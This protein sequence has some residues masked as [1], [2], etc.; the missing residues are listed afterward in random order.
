M[1]SAPAAGPRAAARLL[2]RAMGSLAV[3]LGVLLL[4]L[5]PAPA[6]P[7]LSL[8]LLG[9]GAFASGGRGRRS[10]LP[11]VVAALLVIL[12]LGDGLILPLAGR[13]GAV[14]AFLLLAA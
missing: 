1:S 2:V 5:A 7:G 12:A 14:T 4:A 10:S 13:A 11:P 8:I 3:L 9:A 6:A